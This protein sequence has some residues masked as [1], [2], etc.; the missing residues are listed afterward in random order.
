MPTATRVSCHDLLLSLTPDTLYRDVRRRLAHDNDLQEAARSERRRLDRMCR[1]EK[2]LW[3]E[4]CR[5]VVGTDEVGRGPMAGPLVAAAVAFAVPPFIP[6]LD[7]SKKLTFE[8]REAIFPW[9]Q[10]HALAFRVESI[11]IE[12]VNQG[13]LHELSLRAMTRAVLG[14]GLPA[15]HLLVDG[16]FRLPLDLPQTVLV[17]GDSRSVSIAA[18]SILAKVTRDRFMIEQDRRYPGYNFAS[19]KGYNTPEHMAALELLGPCPLHRTRFAPIQRF[20]D[21]QLTLDL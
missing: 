18:A 5:I 1:E 6:G 9:V 15:E 13:N 10:H 8:Q 3:K 12:E 14:L 7:D 11:P 2:A 16:R 4:G 21:P 20:F 17:K 19:H